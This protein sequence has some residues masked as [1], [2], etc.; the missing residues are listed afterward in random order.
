M[1]D[2]WLASFVTWRM[3][4]NSSSARA[5][6]SV[7]TRASGWSEAGMRTPGTAISVGLL[8][9]IVIDCAPSASFATVREG[10]DRQA[11]KPLGGNR[12]ITVFDMWRISANPIL[13]GFG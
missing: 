2:E 12:E 4:R 6:V 8:K 9:S 13:A 3:S 10:L 5:G 11:T 7:I 1:R